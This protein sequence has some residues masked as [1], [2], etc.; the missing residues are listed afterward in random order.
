MRG[1]AFA[2]QVFAD[3]QGVNATGCIGFD[4]LTEAAGGAGAWEYV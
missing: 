4:A 1:G 3:V 2:Y